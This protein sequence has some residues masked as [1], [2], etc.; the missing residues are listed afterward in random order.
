MKVEPLPKVQPFL[1]QTTDYTSKVSAVD[2][3]IVICFTSFMK[4]SRVPLVNGEFYH[5]FNR[6]VAKMQIF[7]NSYDYSR[8]IKTMR[9]YSILGPKPRF[10]IFTPTTLGLDNTKKIVDIVC[11][12][13]M[14]NHFHILLQQKNEGGISEFLSKLSNSY[15]RYFNER[16]KRIGPLLQGVFKAIHVETDEQLIHLSRY[17]HL[18]PIVSFIV[19]DLE[20]YQW[21]SYPEYLNLLHDEICAKDIILGQFKSSKGYKQFVLDQVDYSKK[22]ERVEHLLLDFEK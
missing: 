18:N 20:S 2:T 7:K 16:S 11:F 10:S 17:I 13:L 21:S 5:V 1:F 4:L 9:Y 3:R 15:T 19:R 14:P 12:C 22:L 6:G 8:F